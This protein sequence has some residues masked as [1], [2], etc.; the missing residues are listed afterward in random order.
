MGRCQTAENPQEIT[1]EMKPEEKTIN[2]WREFCDFCN[3]LQGS[4]LQKDRYEEVIFRGQKDKEQPLTSS[5]YRHL[6]QRNK[7]GS[8]YDIEKKL[9]SEFRK[10]WFPDEMKPFLDNVLFFQLLTIMQHYGIKTRMLDW[11]LSWKVGAYFATEEDLRFNDK[12]AAVWYINRTEIGNKLSSCETYKNITNFNNIYTLSEPRRFC[13]QLTTNCSAR[14]SLNG[15]Q[16]CNAIF[17]KPIYQTATDIRM[18]VQASIL[19]YCHDAK[20]DHIEYVTG[21][22]GED[23]AKNCGKI[24]IPAKLKPEFRTELQEL[25]YKIMPTISEDCCKCLMERMIAE[26]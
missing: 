20:A 14:L 19:T 5:L 8:I 10:Q 12:D 3:K 21:I 13:L 16:Y 15:Q 9:Y 11:T 25:K 6:E 1:D 18:M 26:Y 23:M 17:F 2:S 24:I 22:L 4:D 7:L